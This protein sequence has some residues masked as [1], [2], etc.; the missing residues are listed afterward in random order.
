MQIRINER[1]Q[2]VPD[3]TTL[4]GLRESYKPDADVLIVNGSPVTADRRLSD[5]DRVVLITRGEVPT[6]TELEGLMVARHTPGVHEKVKSA[7]VGVAG[8]GGLGSTVAAALARVGVGTL[9]LADFDVVEPSNLNRQNYFVEH[10]GMRK[11]A[12]TAETL[13]RI[14]PYLTVHTHDVLL[15][16]ANVPVVFGG[17]DV[18]VEAVDSAA[19]KAMIAESFHSAY[20]DIPLVM[21]SGMAGHA[22]AN[23]IRT[24]RLG[25]NTFVAGDLTHEAREGQGLM[26]PRVTVTAAHQANAVLQLLLGE[27]P[28]EDASAG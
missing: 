10:I 16:N 8:L 3:E 23:T 22:S 9:E 17:V 26:S 20:P 21:A 13:R 1:I 25:R 4:L 11:T 5:G 28:G 6:S 7:V 14:N 15:D 12:A 27:A 2:H 19:T 24:R 18:L